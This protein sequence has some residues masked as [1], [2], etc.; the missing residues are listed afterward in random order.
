MWWRFEY[1]TSDK[2]LN[3]QSKNRK[4]AFCVGLLLELFLIF[5]VSTGILVG[6]YEILF[7]VRIQPL[8]KLVG[9]KLL[10]S[11][12]RVYRV[13]EKSPTLQKRLLFYC[14]PKCSSYHLGQ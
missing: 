2:E 8:L 10:Q 7:V 9:L 3:A 14:L 12:N 4:F 13:A 5:L 11:P 1:H 6:S